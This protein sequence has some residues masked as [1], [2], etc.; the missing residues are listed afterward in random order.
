M[1]PKK[2]SEEPALNASLLASLVNDP[3]TTFEDKLECL[4]APYAKWEHKDVEEVV[5]RLK[6]VFRQKNR[7]KEVRLIVFGF[8][9]YQGQIDTI[10]TLYYECR[11]LLL[12]VK[13]KFRKSLIFQLLFIALTIGVVLV[14][15][16]L[17]LLQTQQSDMINM[18]LPK[19]NAII[20]NKDN[21]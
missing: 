2:A 12:L 5:E 11:D 14:L 6:L 13:T 19:R 18:R 17:K 4:K 15:M 16:P 9:L 3:D 1:A 8:A 20:F 21:N 10:R 7:C